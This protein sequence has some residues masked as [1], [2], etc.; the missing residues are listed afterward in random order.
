MLAVELR[1][2]SR[3]RAKPD[4]PRFLSQELKFFWGEYDRLKYNAVWRI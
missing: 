4:T 3:R 2:A 1:I